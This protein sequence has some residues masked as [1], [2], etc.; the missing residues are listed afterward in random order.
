MIKVRIEEIE[1]NLVFETEIPELPKLDHK[2][3]AWFNGV[4][5]ICSIND[6]IHEFD[7]D[8]KFLLVEIGVISL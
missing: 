2:I 3:G 6:I 4:W 7:E 5:C 8:G 1:D